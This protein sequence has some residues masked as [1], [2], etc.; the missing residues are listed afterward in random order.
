MQVVP[1]STDP[2]RLVTGSEFQDAHIGEHPHGPILKPDWRPDEEGRGLGRGIGQ[3]GDLGQPA[4]RLGQTIGVQ[5]HASG[6]KPVRDDQ[7]MDQR[8]GR[9]P[10]VLD[11]PAHRWVVGPARIAGGRE[12]VGERLEEQVHGRDRERQRLDRADRF[13]CQLGNQDEQS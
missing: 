5:L 8:L 1:Q 12:P 2:P 9:I 6:E 3:L 11:E 10:A 7:G 13:G 4:A